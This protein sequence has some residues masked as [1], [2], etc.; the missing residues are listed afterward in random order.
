MSEIPENFQRLL[1]QS[2]EF[3]SA[4]TPLSL[5]RRMEEL[6]PSPYGVSIGVD[7]DDDREFLYVGTQNGDVLAIVP[8][9][10]TDDE[11]A[12]KAF[13]LAQVLTMLTRVGERAVEAEAERDYERAKFDEI[14]EVVTR[15]RDAALAGIVDRCL[16]EP[17]NPLA[18]ELFDIA[19]AAFQDTPTVVA[20][21]AVIAS[22]KEH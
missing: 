9:D 5:Y 4:Y 21:I 18:A 19:T 6:H 11:T 1:R 16:E 3:S 22:R 12:F 17:D 15:S 13:Y 7:R 14:R 10:T 2:Q 8:G 20:Q